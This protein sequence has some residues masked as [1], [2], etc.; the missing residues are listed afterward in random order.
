MRNGKLEDAR[1]EELT[2]GLMEQFRIVKNRPVELEME[3]KVYDS[4]SNGAGKILKAYMVDLA[5]KQLDASSI[6]TKLIE[7]E[8]NG[9]EK[10]L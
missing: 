7:G 10:S 9:N 8:Q 4:M 2:A 1:L 6:N 5:Y 3:M